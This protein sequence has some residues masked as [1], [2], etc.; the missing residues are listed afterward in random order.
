VGPAPSTLPRGGTVAQTCSQNAGTS[1]QITVIG[2]PNEVNLYTST[3][4]KVVSVAAGSTCA[5]VS[6]TVVDS[7]TV[8]ASWAATNPGGICQASFVVQDAQSKQ[9]AG[10][11]NGSVTVDLQGFP[12]PPAS[13]VQTS[14]DNGS[15]TLRATQ[16]AA[17]YPAIT[18][19]AVYSG[20]SRVATCSVDGA[21]TTIGGLTNGDKRTYEVKSV[22]AEGESR[23]SVSTVAWSY[24]APG[25]SSVTATA[26][27]QSGVTTPTTGVVDVEIVSQDRDTSG[28]DV[29]GV[30]GTVPKQPGSTTTVRMQFEPGERSITVNPVSR[31]ERPAGNGPVGSSST[32]NVTVIGAPTI[33]AGGGNPSATINSI[34]VPA[35]TTNGNYSPRPIA[36]LY[37]AYDKLA[38]RP[39]CSAGPEGGLRVNAPLSSS[40]TTIRDVQDNTEYNLTVCGSNG[41]GVAQVD[42]GT[43]FTWSSPEAPPASTYTISDGSANGR[44]L[45]DM[46]EF[47]APRKTTVKT[48][49]VPEWGAVGDLSVAYCS[50]VVDTVCTDSTAIKP[51]EQG[52]A[53]QMQI[54]RVTI[55]SCAAGQKLRVDISGEGT[56]SAGGV[57]SEFE[58]LTV[59]STG[60]LKWAWID[61]DTIPTNAHSVRNVKITWTADSAKALQ[62]FK[63]ATLATVA[64]TPVPTT[65]PVT[66]T[67]TPSAE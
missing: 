22:N 14:Y 50:T 32:T 47:T 41:F 30:A 15:I 51:V 4:L 5:G 64:C 12:Q 23:A 2:T 60:V 16:G 7:S 24:D 58:Y 10:D 11:R 54:D 43:T 67:P 49:E 45:I 31:F 39:E 53:H 1:C 44:Y 52:R 18:G 34:T 37:I 17:S 62:P 63:T 20:A 61:G 33:T 66:P 8:Q 19:F 57:V 40:G 3:P 13:L 59:S 35:A 9:S 42:A 27:Y 55:A 6:F 38:S 28:F 46:P 48:S 29:T 26:V 36:T 56:N 21:C 65:P 25:I